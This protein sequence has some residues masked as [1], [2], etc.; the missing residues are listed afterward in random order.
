MESKEGEHNLPPKDAD[1]F[2]AADDAGAFTERNLASARG[3]LGTRA[4]EVKGASEGIPATPSQV[5][6]DLKVA[7][8]KTE[9]KLIEESAPKAITAQVI[10]ELEDDSSEDSDDS[11][12][13][14]KRKQKL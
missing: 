4:S 3:L 6:S 12:V 2:D 1:S 7:E 13:Q 8:Q 14:K 10:N 5:A 11:D 9:A